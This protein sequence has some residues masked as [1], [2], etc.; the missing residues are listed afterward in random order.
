MYMYTHFL[1][2]TYVFMYIIYMHMIRTGV[3]VIKQDWMEGVLNNNN[4]LLKKGIC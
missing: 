4:L 2:A 3:T 1:K